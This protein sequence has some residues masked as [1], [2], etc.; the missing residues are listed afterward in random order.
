[1]GTNGY[2]E[3]YSSESRLI[4]A[5]CYVFIL[6]VPALV[7]ASDLRGQRFLRYHAYQGLGTGLVL[8]V[9]YFLLLPVATWILLHVPC[10]GWSFACL[11]PFIYLAGLG[12]QMYWAY[13]AYQGHIFSIPILG[14]LATSHLGD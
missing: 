5:L 9:L 11:A 12:L 1:M 14:N 3:P 6:I 4:A 2:G 7:L 8:L 10:V 13:L